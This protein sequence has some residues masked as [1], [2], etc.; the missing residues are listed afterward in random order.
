MSLDRHSPREA[1]RLNYI[2]HVTT[3]MQYIKENSNVIADVIS[4]KCLLSKPRPENELRQHS[5][6]KSS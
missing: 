4:Q 1:Q 6:A 3:D 2:S 5:K